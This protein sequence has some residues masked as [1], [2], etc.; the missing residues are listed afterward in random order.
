MGPTA[1]EL[2]LHY[3][4]MCGSY[5]CRIKATTTRACVGSTAVE[6]RLQLQEHV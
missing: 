5:C 6:L 2:R 4:S 3:T 1:V